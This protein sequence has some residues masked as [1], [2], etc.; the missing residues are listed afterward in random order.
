MFDAQ[1]SLVMAN[2]WFVDEDTLQPLSQFTISTPYRFDSQGK[3]APNWSVEPSMYFL[4][5]AQPHQS[6]INGARHSKDAARSVLNVF[7]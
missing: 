2:G 7:I 4:L 6:S 1:Y 5:E 3:Y